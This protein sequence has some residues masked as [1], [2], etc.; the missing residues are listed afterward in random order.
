[1]GT[2]ADLLEFWRGAAELNDEW[3]CNL[4]VIQRVGELMRIPFG[5]HEDDAGVHGQ[6]QVLVITWALLQQSSAHL[7]AGSFLQC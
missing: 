6:E 1:M 2:P 4:P 5:F 7:I 3:Y